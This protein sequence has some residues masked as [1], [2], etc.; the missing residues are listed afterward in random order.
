MLPA[1]STRLISG[2][3]KQLFTAGRFSSKLRLEYSVK[4]E[5]YHGTKLLMP[6]GKKTSC[7]RRRAPD[8]RARKVD[9]WCSGPI[10]A[11]LITGE[12]VYTV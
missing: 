5:A 6:L 3:T 7:K 1:L 2:L 12:D 11:S 9:P 4:I 10:S 8:F